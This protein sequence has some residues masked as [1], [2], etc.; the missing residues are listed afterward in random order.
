GFKL[1]INTTK[2]RLGE[3]MLRR[4]RFELYDRCLRFPPHHLRKVKQAEIATMI[5]DEV[6]PLGGFIGDAF[7]QPAFLGGQALTAL[8]FIMWQSV[9]LGS[10]ALAVLLLQAIIIPKLRVKV[11]MLGKA[12]QLT[13]RQLA[14]RV[15]ET[16]DGMA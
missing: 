16:V 9:W 15:A 14:G 5:K 1:H 2:G 8:A 11:L 13:A 10:V 12:R 7:V 3:R 4:L 6:E